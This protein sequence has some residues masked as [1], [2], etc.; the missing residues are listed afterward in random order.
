MIQPEAITLSKIR[1]YIP[2]SVAILIFKSLMMSKIGY[3]GILCVGAAKATFQKLRRS[4]RVCFC[5]SRY[6]S[7][8]R[9]HIDSNV[10]PL[11]LRRK[12]DMYKYMYSK[13][14]AQEKGLVNSST[15]PNTRFSLAR[16]LCLKGQILIDF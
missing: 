16:P 9:L 3:G 5:A 6:T 14:L 12:L 13:M 10:L 8:I 1:R 2:E 4:L 11:Y 7:N 15:R